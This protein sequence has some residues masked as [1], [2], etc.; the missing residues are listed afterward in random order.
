MFSVAGVMPSAPQGH[1]EFTAK[2]N[3]YLEREPFCHPNALQRLGGQKEVSYTTRRLFL[4]REGA[5]LRPKRLTTVG[6]AQRG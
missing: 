4:P 2:V 5:F 1:E 6:G 3:L